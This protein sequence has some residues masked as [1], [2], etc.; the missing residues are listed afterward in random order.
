MTVPPDDP[1][2]ASRLRPVRRPK[3]GAVL[4]GVL[5]AVPLL[6]AILPV[7]PGAV[8]VGGVALAWW[9][10]GVLAPLLGLGVAAWAVPGTGPAGAPHQRR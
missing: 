2:P 9:Y 5:L 10:A 8:R 1:R 7:D 6:S 4:L 3:A